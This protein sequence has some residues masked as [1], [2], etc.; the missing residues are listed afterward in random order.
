MSDGGKGDK[1]RPFSVDLE[2]YDKQFEAIF[3]KTLLKESCHT[4]RK[5]KTWCTCVKVSNESK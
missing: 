4:C 5:S 1:P 3:G 2:K